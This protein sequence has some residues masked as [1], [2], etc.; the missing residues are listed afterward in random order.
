[1]VWG[2]RHF[3]AY[4]YGHKVTVFTDHAPVKSML[5]TTHPSGK[6]ARWAESVAE[7]D[8]EI[9]YRPGRKNSNADALSRSP[10]ENPSSEEEP[11]FQVAAVTAEEAPQSVPDENSKIIECQSEDHCFDPLSRVRNSTF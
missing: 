8:V 11:E 1:M 10:Q 7:L 9:K 2:L 4:L 6:L 3:R 5:N